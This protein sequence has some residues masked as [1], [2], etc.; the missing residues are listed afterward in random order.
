M[1]AGIKNCVSPDN[2]AS[3]RSK[4]R[5]GRLLKALRVLESRIAIKNCHA[6]RGLNAC[7]SKLHVVLHFYSIISG[8][9]DKNLR[10]TVH[11]NG[12]CHL[13][14]GLPYQATRQGRAKL[15]NVNFGHLSNYQSVGITR[16]RALDMIPTYLAENLSQ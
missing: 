11:D 15:G 6:A 2:S 13:T 4:D 7:S 9:L 12:M 16:L 10:C 1:R 3:C 8:I 14:W 5:N